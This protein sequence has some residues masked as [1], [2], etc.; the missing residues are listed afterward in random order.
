MMEAAREGHEEMVA[1]LLFHDADINAITEE[2]QETAL[3]L[4]C[5]GGC[6]EVAK[7]LLEAGADANL[8]AASTPLME[9]AQEGHLELVQLLVK[10]GALVNKF[11]TTTTSIINNSSGNNPANNTNS[12]TLTSCESAL[13]LSCENGHT[14]VVDFLIKSGGAEFDRADPEKGYTPL[15]K[16]CRTGQ[17]CTVTYL[18]ANYADKIDINRSTLRNEHNALSLACQ[19]G[20]L[21]I[22][23]LLLQHGANPLQPLKDNS[24][25]LIEASK[26]GH[27][28]I[29]ELLI[30]WNYTLNISNSSRAAK[31]QPLID[32]NN[33]QELTPK[34]CCHHNPD[35]ANFFDDTSKSANL[36][37]KSINKSNL[38]KKPKQEVRALMQQEAEPDIIKQIKKSVSRLDATSDI[39]LE[40]LVNVLHNFAFGDAQS[41]EQC[42]VKPGGNDVNY[43]SAVKST[44]K[45]LKSV[46]SHHHCTSLNCHLLDMNADFRELLRENTHEEAA[47]NDEN[48][49]CSCEQQQFNFDNFCSNLNSQPGSSHSSLL[50]LSLSIGKGKHNES[51]ESSNRCIEFE[52]KLKQELMCDEAKYFDEEDEDEQIKRKENL[53]HELVKIEKQLEL[54][55]K[56]AAFGSPATT[57]TSN[58]SS[59]YDHISMINKYL[60]KKCQ[61]DLN[62][63]YKS[64]LK[65]LQ[66]RPAADEPPT[67]DKANKLAPQKTKTSFSNVTSAGAAAAVSK[68]AKKRFISSSSSSSSSSSFSSSK[69]S[70]SAVNHGLSPPS[71]KPYQNLDFKQLIAAQQDETQQAANQSMQT[72]S[73][74]N[75]LV[76]FKMFSNTNQ[77][78]VVANK[79]SPLQPIQTL[80]GGGGMGRPEMPTLPVSLSDIQTTLYFKPSA[81]TTQ[82]TNPVVSFL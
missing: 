64:K 16:A 81:A 7:F 6:Y 43:T 30:D 17:V 82:A 70:F 38:S 78:A 35:A 13:T 65:Q 2:T 80:I 25:C 48:V 12:T 24:N 69:N 75:S 68:N 9:A 10:A 77:E 15:M 26:G 40:S 55:K 22:A 50:H 32:L 79:S 51:V 62:R 14:D 18:L 44:L 52:S 33:Q 74:S 23:E 41:M 36:K 31:Q 1:L 66:Q 27:I 57:T 56:T 28:K 47:H 20:H 73:I 67:L 11:T 61:F 8:G 4:A 76:E 39:G 53:L 34:M 37:N 3:T 54:Q 58:N 72:Q 63:L 29:V 45:K 59:N 46:S 49:T 5:C 71:A 21:Q 60:I 42:P 19:N